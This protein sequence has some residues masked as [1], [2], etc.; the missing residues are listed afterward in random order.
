MSKE[1][2]NYYAII[3]A[4]VRYDEKLIQGAKLLYGEITALSNQKG[5]CW[6][7]DMYFSTLYKVSK[8]TIQTW[9]KSLEAQGYLT[10]EV[11]YKEGSNE[12]VSRYIRLSVY[13]MHEKVGTPMHEKVRDNNTSINNTVNNTNNIKELTPSKKQKAK[14]VRH[15]YGE[16]KNVLLSDED[17]AK[18]Q[19][20]FPTDWEKRIEKL[21]EYCESK[22]VTYKNYL[23]T[24]RAW[25]RR[26]KNKPKKQFGTYNASNRKETMPDWSNQPKVDVAAANDELERR[27][28]AEGKLP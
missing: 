13:P 16:Y 28:R 10:R 24:I 5:Y 2:P 18:L 1:E 21:S 6:A 17:L 25:A 14:P 23:A 15:K 20:E 22:G 11:I 27:L 3:P 7:N 4:N 12:I 19:K 8:K 9:L 26:D